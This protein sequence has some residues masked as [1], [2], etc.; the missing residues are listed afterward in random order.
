MRCGK[1]VGQ[2]PGANA[3]GWAAL[4]RGICGLEVI[5]FLRRIGRFS[6]LGLACVVGTVGWTTAQTS[7]EPAHLILH[8]LDYI[9]V[10]YP[11]FVQD[12]Q[13]LDQAEYEEQLE[14]SRQVLETL[15]HLPAHVEQPN[16]LR[17]AEQLL[18]RI[19]DK[20]AGLEVAAL[21]QQLR[22][23]IIR[24]YAIEVAPKRPPDLRTAATLYQAQCAA[25]HGAQGQGDGPAGASLDPAPS[26]FHDRQRMDQRSVYGLYSTITLGVQGTGMSGFQALGEDERWALAFYVSNFTSPEADVQRGAELWQSGIG[27]S[28]FPDLA[29]LVTQTAS[30]TRVTYG[31]D[32]LRLLAYLLQNPEAVVSS[33]ESPL[34]RSSRLLGDSLAAYAQGQVQSAHDLAISAYLDGFELV[35]ASLDTVD[36]RLRMT[37][38][39]EMMRYRSLLKSRAE[40]STVAATVERVQG[41]LS[42]AQR[43][44]ETTRLPTGAVF[45]SAF[46]ILLREGLEA[47]LVL[48]AI[49]AL[50]IKGERRDALPYVHAGWVAALALGGITWFVASY[51]VAISGSTREVTEGVT[52]LVAAAVLLYVGF[53][54]HDKAYAERWRT[55]LQS[56]LHEALS[57]RTM[58]ALALVSFLAVYREAFE[59]VLFY[60]ALWV[61]VAPHHLPVLGGFVGAAATLAILGWLI[62]RG[63]VRLP[64]GLFF[65]ATSWL[66][67]L[68]AVVFAGKGVAA[69]Q[70]A[71]RLPLDAVSFPGVPAL[72]LYPTLQGLVLQALILLLVAGVF[73]Y[74]R[75]IAKGMR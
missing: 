25:C 55:F 31:D 20:K 27:R 66:L 58:G 63:S 64:L 45:L 28:W 3:D 65:G 67:V 51:V 56:Q 74:M 10:D 43:A 73:L 69:L 7:S 22:R 21:A 23:D 42:E 2:P 18:N 34:A 75:Y 16:L 53:W 32:A 36:R 37:I 47:I 72:G 30:S 11:E 41:L 12:G 35:E 39:T 59:T 48:A 38:E 70:E 19:Q 4:R 8:M 5:Y 44:I 33:T 49:Y 15:G 29:S 13:V 40:A 14:F 61:Q 46:V 26:N 60:Q 24:A 17:S 57:S 9:A 54:M 52:A 1:K 71:G 68:L 62:F 50:L 6:V